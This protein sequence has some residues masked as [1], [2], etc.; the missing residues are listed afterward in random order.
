M[1][2]GEPLDG[3][4]VLV[5]AEQG[6]G[7]EI[8]FASCF[9]DLIERAGHVTV[10]CA[11]RLEPLFSRSF[12]GATVH[13]VERDESLGWLEDRSAVDVK[14]IA[15]NLPRYLRPSE[16]SFTNCGG[17]LHVD[18]RAVATWRRRLAALGDV[19][20]VGLSWRGGK[21]AVDRLQ[22]SIDLEHWR[23][24]LDVEG[25]QFVCVQ[26]GAHEQ[27][28]ERVA[29]STER[30]VVRFDEIDPAG[31]AGPGDLR[32]QLDRAPGRRARRAGVGRAPVRGGLALDA[33]A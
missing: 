9:P 13:G 32:G 29:A 21:S 31:R 14:C 16:D 27:E 15:G 5:Y 20:K 6:I 3:R 24:V 17:F 7:D 19:P 12:P 28:V 1:W 26:Y 11:P 8:M 25:V 2:E 23:P 10:Q 33:G 18:S 22:R 4:H 30:R